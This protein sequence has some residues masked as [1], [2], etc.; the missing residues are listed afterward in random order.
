LRVDA[1]VDDRTLREQYRAGFERVVRDEQPWTVMCAYN[2]LNGVYASQHR[3]LL[4]EVLRDEWGFEGLV[5]SDWGA[6][7]DRA[8]AVAAGLDLEMPS[9]KGIGP[10]RAI[11]AI[12]AGELEAPDLDRAV[13]RVLHLVDR[14]LANLAPDATFDVDT[15][16]ALARVA[17]ADGIVLLKNERELLPLPSDASRIAVIGEL[18][19]TPRYQGAGSS[20]VNPTRLDSPLDELLG[21]LAPTVVVDFAQ[22]YSV[23]D[24]SVDLDALRAEAASL[25]DGADRV[26]LFLGLPPSAES[27][28]FDRTH[29][30][31]PPEQLAL[32]AAVHDVNDSVVVVLSNGGVVE[33]A[34]WQH[35][36]DAIV[37]GW[38]LGQAGGGALADVLVGA[39]NPSGRLAETIP[40]A[41][42]DTSAHLSFPGDG[43]EVIYGEGVFVGYRCYDTVGREVAFPF[44]H[45]LSYTTFDYSDV[46]VDVLDSAEATGW[47]GAPRVSVTVAVTNTGERAGKEVVQLYVGVPSHSELRPRHELRGFEKV[48]LEPGASSRVSFTLHDRDLATWSSRAQTWVVVPGAYVVEIGASSRDVRCSATVEVH[49]E[50]TPPPLDRDST[51]GEWLEHPTGRERLLDVLRAA[52]GG[53]LSPLV[54]DRNRVRVIASFPLPRLLTML[55]GDAGATMLGALLATE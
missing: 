13:E 53:D 27:E 10:R 37:E 8:A 45:G 3:W 24:T 33:T 2:R 23:D 50:L 39:V 7:D 17:A 29:L 22:G 21:A 52:P 4:T 11:A 32:L 41:L 6:V 49:G 38:L 16:H 54:E 19:R 15:H 51:L 20:R 55:A 28:G 9:S 34:S 42:H 44:G 26:V 12:E 48:A 14:S 43:R 31:L 18:A 36:A 47:R 40:I 1:V 35:H 30:A 46:H 25:A 5:M